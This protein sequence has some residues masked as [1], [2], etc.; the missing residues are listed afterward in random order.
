MVT[1]TLCPYC[2]KHI[3]PIDLI[4]VDKTIYAT[5]Y[6]CPHCKKILSVG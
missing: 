3:S 1:K 2:E 5:I 4:V 6:A